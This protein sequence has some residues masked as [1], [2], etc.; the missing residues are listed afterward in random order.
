[1]SPYNA[2]KK[3]LHREFLYLDRDTIANSLSALEAGMIDEIIQKAN[4]SREGG[5]GAGL[6]AGPAELSAAKKRASEVEEELVIKRTTFSVFQAWHERLIEASAFGT[7]DEWNLGVSEELNVGDTLEFTATLRL[8]PLHMLIRTY[9]AYAND[10]SNQDSP[11]A[12]HGAEL[13]ETKRLARQISVMAG[14]REG[15]PDKIPVYLAPFGI[16]E[17]RMLASLDDRY[18]VRSKED[19][20]G[21]F[22]VIAQVDQMLDEGGEIPISRF[23]SGVPP[24][25]LEVKVTGEAWGHMIEP[26]KELGVEISGDDIMVPYPAVSVRPIAIWR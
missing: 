19:I 18:L 8:A 10:A 21:T 7:F 13:K 14:L 16:E 5:F 6:R 9:L 1:M 2:P 22:R 4:E 15:D 26:A 11:M 24:T 23:F 17:P 3:N 25:P 20:E 12:Q